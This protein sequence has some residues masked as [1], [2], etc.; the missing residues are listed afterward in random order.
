MQHFIPVPSV[1]AGVDVKPGSRLGCSGESLPSIYAVN[2][3]IL[4]HSMRAGVVVFY[5]IYTQNI[6]V[7]V[8]IVCD[9]ILWVSNVTCSS[10]CGIGV[11]RVTSHVMMCV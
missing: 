6:V 8:V 1:V 7:H 11:T 4:N 9:T 3:F 10:C 2:H 5:I